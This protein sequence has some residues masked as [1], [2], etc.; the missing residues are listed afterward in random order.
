VARGLTYIL[1]DGKKIR[2]WLDVWVGNCSLRVAF[3]RLFEICNHQEWSVARVLRDGDLN[4][5]FRR[6]LG[7]AQGVEWA[8]LTAL[9]EGVSFS[10]RPDSVKWILEKNGCFSTAS[11]YRELFFPGVVN[12]WMMSIWRAGLPLKIKIF[13]WQICNDKI[14]SAE[15]LKKKNWSG[16]LECKLCSEVE[17]TKHFFFLNCALAKFSWSLFNDALEW[18]SLP[19]TLD[20]IHCKLVEGS[21]RENGLFVFLFGCLAWSLWLIRNDLIFNNSVVTY[22]DMCIFRTISFMQRW[23]ILHKEKAQL[24]IASVI[25]KLR[26]QLSLLNSED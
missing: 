2:F 5:T 23:S 17:S 22:P 24:W 19:E 6:N 21:N 9:M 20:D 10:P 13:L 18:G 3:P 4:L 14:Q 25:H 16:P 26:H 7:A 1:G 8:A 15:Q 11:L 12:K